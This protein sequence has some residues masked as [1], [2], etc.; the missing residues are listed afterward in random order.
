M[1]A[2]KI[3]S[4]DAMRRAGKRLAKL[5]HSGDVI[6]LVGDLG[7]GKTVFVKGLAEGLGTDPVRVASPT[8]TLINEY[9]GGR[10]VLHHVDL[11]RLER[12][13]ELSELGLEE[14]VGGEG[15]CAIEWV[16]RFATSAGEDWLEVRIAFAPPR[17]TS[18]RVD[19]GAGGFGPADVA[20]IVE[21]VPHGARARSLA[22][23]W[24]TRRH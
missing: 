16:D 23:E 10:L 2:V 6:G 12:A 24:D 22:A 5:L 3:T 8:F 18:S 20:R 15:V 21:M 14:I 17:G 1:P 9:R 7:A 4:P 11:Y 13:E 19:V